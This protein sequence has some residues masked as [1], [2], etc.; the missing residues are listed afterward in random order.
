MSK[1]SEFFYCY[2]FRLHKFLNDQ[3]ISAIDGG[4]NSFDQ[5]IFWQYKNDTEFDKAFIEFKKIHKLIKPNGLKNKTYLYSHSLGDLDKYKSDLLI[6]NDWAILKRSNRL[7]VDNI[8]KYGKVMDIKTKQTLEKRIK[9]F[10]ENGYLI[11]DE[12]YFEIPLYSDL[13]TE[14][15]DGN[16]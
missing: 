3:G 13:S 4:L 8:Q 11:E 5:K 9:L 6:L 15:E 10:C 16:L 1:D 12:E 7:T 14:L 2:S